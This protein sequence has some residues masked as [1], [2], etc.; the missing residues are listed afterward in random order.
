MSSESTEPLHIRD[1]LL[2]EMERAA[3]GPTATELGHG[4]LGDVVAGQFQGGF[5]PDP[6]LGILGKGGE[7]VDF[8]ENRQEAAGTVK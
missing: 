1:S 6:G 4:E 7:A 8:L 5:A 2:V 3:Q